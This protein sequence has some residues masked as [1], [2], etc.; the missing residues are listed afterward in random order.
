M[1]ETPHSDSEVRE[2]VV[3]ALCGMLRLTPDYLGGRLTDETIK[4]NLEPAKGFVRANGLPT[5][6]VDDQWIIGRVKMLFTIYQAEA[7]KLDGREGDHEEWL[8]NKKTEL[9]KPHGYWDNYRRLLETRIK[10]D[11]PVRVLDESTDQVLAS[12]E[13]P[14]RPGQWDRRGLVMGHVQSGKTNHYC[15]L[16]AKGADAGYKLIVVL[17][18]TFN[19]LRAQTQYRID[20]A[21]IGRDTTRG[22]DSVH[23]IGV[24]HEA[25]KG[26]IMSLRVWWDSILARSMCPR[27]W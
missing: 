10:A 15:G 8:A 12:F 6:S 3:D 14:A 16:I 27:F 25:V 19:N 4:R 21:L 1:S 24:G 11:R 7:A 9:F 18:G 5:D 20:E 26:G 17:A 13:N 2:R 23:P 22:P